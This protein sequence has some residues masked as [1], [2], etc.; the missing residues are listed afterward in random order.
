VLADA[1]DSDA[2]IASAINNAIS[3]VAGLIGVSAV[4]A[5]VAGEL[6]AGTFGHNSASITAFHHVVAICGVLVAA[7][8]VVGLLGIVDKK[9]GGVAAAGCAGGQ[10]VGA[11]VA[12]AGSRSQ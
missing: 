9:K 7:G 4:G 12:A 11:P 5:A 8:G 6:P 1:D 10:L 3:R 2:G